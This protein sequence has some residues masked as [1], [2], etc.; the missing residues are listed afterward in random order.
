MRRWVP[1]VKGV[2]GLTLIVWLV[3][4]TDAAAL[5]AAW[6]G[7]SWPAALAA[8]A[9]FAGLVACLTARYRFVLARIGVA[10]P[11]GR[12]VR[13]YLMGL[14]ANQFLPGMLGGDILRAA[15]WMPSH[16]DKKTALSAAVLAERTSGLATMVLLAA[17][18]GWLLGL[19]QREWLWLAIAGT[20]GAV[21]LAGVSLVILWGRRPPRGRGWGRVGR[22]VAAGVSTLL[23]S[24]RTA[25]VIG[26]L[27]LGSQVCGV[28]V[29]WFL[30]RG[31]GAGTTVV[32]A[33]VGV[34]LAWLAGMLPVTLN[35]LGVR[36]AG[37]AAV[38]AAT[39]TDRTVAAA[40]A[41][42]A[43][44]LMLVHALAGGALWVWD[45]PS[46]RTPDAET[47]P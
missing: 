36:E 3:S 33:G 39:G 41:L 12:A 22:D 11:P 7:L 34:T 25:G 6:Q 14:F 9:A 4:R 21:L 23:A 5:S 31:L 40:A 38:L 24:P 10:C 17:T 20:G 2:V 16:P 32:Q 29:Y 35:G 43:L 44:G 1:A 28:G 8:W 27:S 46:F 15:Y 30:L 26:L 42:L 13:V 45:R 18:G 37:F 47:T 19:A